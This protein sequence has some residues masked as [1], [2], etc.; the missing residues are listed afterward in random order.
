LV[1]RLLP[2]FPEW[3]AR[4][5]TTLLRERGRLDWWGSLERALRPDDVAR[6]A[7]TL[8][9]LLRGWRKQER[10]HRTLELAA[11]LRRRLEG[12]PGLVELVENI[13]RTTR[14]QWLAERGLWLL[15]AYARPRLARLV[16]QL[17]HEDPTW[18][19]V[20]V[21]ANHLHRHRQDLLTPYLGQK[22]IRG[23]FHTGKTTYLLPFTDGFFRWTGTQQ[24]AF[25]ATLGRVIE[26]ADPARDVVSVC[27]AL[28]QLAALPAVA[29]DP[30]LAR[31]ADA[32]L[33]V[34]D[35]ALRLLG[36]LDGGGGV[37]TLIE[38]LEDD[39]ARVA[40][41]ALRRTLLAM[42]EAHA[43][44]LLRRVSMK[45]VTVAK[46]VVRLVGERDSD[47][48][49]AFLRELEASRP[50]RDVQVAL[51]RAAWSHLDRAEAWEMFDR[52]V[53]RGDPALLPPAVRIPADGLP[54]DG[55]RRLAAL[56][57]RVLENPA[58]E[59]RLEVLRRCAAAPPEDPQRVLLPAV[60]GRLGTAGPDER[61]AA[62][63]AAVALCDPAD[64]GRVAR[65]LRECLPQRRAV[66][67]LVGALTFALAGQKRRLGPV[68]RAVLKT[69]AEDP[70]V[71]AIGV[72]L[73]LRALP[74]RA[75]LARLLGA[76]A[77]RLDVMQAAVRVLEAGAGRQPAE[78][79][80]L[81]GQLARSA[82]A[83][84]RRLAL[85]AL[86]GQAA[87]T[88]WNADR[89]ERLRAYR[90]DPEPLMASAAQLTLPAEEE[91][92]TAGQE[93]PEEDDL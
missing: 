10:D 34:R 57:V 3:S 35:T 1:F 89:L 56:L 75:V 14:Q 66:L 49:F 71:E 38:A 5:L 20:A 8:L 2:R 58:P 23:R 69:L 45:R 12:F 33:A 46:E 73:A 4:W 27:Q 61:D 31:A 82:E 40:V 55:R 48:A 77:W 30:V 16:P 70:L 83:P 84:P 51:L 92:G 80:R 91:G 22:A 42:P 78:L 39:R 15:R 21:V 11:A 65:G 19:T 81:E 72:E 88:G 54:A 74:E 26:D 60:L 41:Y 36:R 17:L 47:A 64:A 9:P 50:H 13:I 59:V 93:R 62:A 85:A 79:R 25:A 28:R 18:V 86:V 76:A 87:L 32:R 90:R 68:A 53:E 63:R 52:A 6:I 44:D 43:L 24:Q 7:P 67:A 29:P 37:G